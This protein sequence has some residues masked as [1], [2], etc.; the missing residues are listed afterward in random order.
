MRNI[1]KVPLDNVAFGHA[2]Q[3][4]TANAIRTD[5]LNA[6]DMIAATGYEAL[7]NI[8]K[9]KYKLI[10]TWALATVKPGPCKISLPFDM[11]KM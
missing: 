7:F 11:R 9:Y 10:S 8:P 2:S 4:A 1:T 3:R 5:A 6:Q